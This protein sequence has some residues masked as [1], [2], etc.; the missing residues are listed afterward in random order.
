MQ[1]VI[2][3]FLRKSIHL[4]A[5]LNV[6]SIHIQCYFK[7]VPWARKVFIW[8]SCCKRK[9]DKKTQTYQNLEKKPMKRKVLLLWCLWKTHLVCASFVWMLSRNNITKQL[10]RNKILKDRT[11]KSPF[12]Q[13]NQVGW[14]TR[15]NTRKNERKISLVS[16]VSFCGILFLSFFLCT[17]IKRLEVITSMLLNI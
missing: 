7:H 2:L 9:I 14:K 8:F 6:I 5:V 12:Q 17:A 3:Y 10:K 11:T 4:W 13:T 1:F 16:L 15:R